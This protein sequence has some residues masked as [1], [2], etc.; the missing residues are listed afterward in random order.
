[1]SLRGQQRPAERDDDS[2]SRLRWAGNGV[3]GGAIATVVMTA[4]R[5]PVTTSLPPSAEFWATYVSGGEPDEHP[6]AALLLHLGY[7]AAAGG[8]F[9]VLFRLAMRG[10]LGD[11]DGDAQRDRLR[12]VLG[13]AAGIAYGLALSVFGRRLLI[14]RLLP[15]ELDPTERF[16]FHVSHVVYG[17]SL[18][19]WV[20]A[21]M[22]VDEITLD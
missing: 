16:V 15:M 22:T 19:S 7:G 12:E 17:L 11:P 20:A 5:M 13:L 9:G 10:R 2:P 1:M 14:D 21:Q 4:Y 6:V 8:V 3:V 18:G